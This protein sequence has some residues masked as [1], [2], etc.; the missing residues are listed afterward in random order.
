MDKR[1]KL[2]ILIIIP[3]IVLISCAVLYFSLICKETKDATDSNKTV[4]INEI[5]KNP[6]EYNNPTYLQSL[7]TD[8]RE[9]IINSF[10]YL[11][12][13]ECGN[14]EL[15]KNCTS[16]L[17]YSYMTLFLN[18]GQYPSSESMNIINNTYL[19]FKSGIETLTESNLKGFDIPLLS[20]FCRMGIL[21]DEER[22]YWLKKLLDINKTN[23]KSTD[24]QL[25][26]VKWCLGAR[27]ITHLSEIS[28][29]DL[30]DLNKKMCDVL[31][32]LKDT[33][34]EDLCDVF[35]CMNTRAFCLIDITS[36]DKNILESLISK[37]CETNYQKNCKEKLLKFYNMY[38]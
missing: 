29:L 13:E 11:L 14:G 37:E 21:N 20:T 1:L 3:L 15:N 26:Y 27:N 17:L 35:D 19:D 28:E 2:T 30:K 16:Y 23:W 24:M 22:I 4:G 9:N 34:V 10:N 38:K 6:N 25:F 36:E 32:E 12:E 7:P 8:Q 33:G 31:P 5:F 18:V